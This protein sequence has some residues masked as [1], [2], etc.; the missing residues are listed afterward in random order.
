MLGEKFINDL[1]GSMTLQEK[2]AEMTQIW[3]E[4]PDGTLMGILRGF[5]KNAHLSENAGSLLGFNGAERVLEAQRIHMEENAHHIPLLFMTDVI[6]GYKTVFPSVLGL[7]ASWDPDLIEQSASV[8][9]AEASVSGVHVTFSP[10]ADLVRDARWGRV[11][12][13]TGEDSFLNALCAAAFTRGY[14]GSGIDRPLRIAACVKHFIGYGAVEG[15]RDYDSVQMSDYELYNEYLPAF[16]AA[17]DAGCEL[18]MPAFNT[19][20]GIPCSASR[21]LL[22][23]LLREELNFRGTVISD[24]TAVCELA[25]H[26][27]CE[28]NGQ[29]ASLALQ[30]GM[31][32]EM[33]SSTFYEHLT[34]LVESGAVGMHQ[35]DASVKR[36]LTLKDKM[37][38]FENPYKDADPEKEKELH[39]CAGH[40]RLAR[41]AAAKSLVLLKND[42]HVLPLGQ[43]EKLAL[44]GPFADSRQLLDIWGQVNGEEKDCVTLREALS[45]YSVEYAQGCR[46]WNFRNLEE[47]HLP[48]RELIDAAQALAAKS[49]KVIL[50]LGEHPDMS[51]E[52]GSRTDITLPENQTELLKAVQATGK[53]V[54]TIILAGRPLVLNTVSE[55]SS[56]L[57]FAWFPGTE[58][59]NGIADVL[60]GRYAP[61]ARLPMSFPR[62]V[63]QAPLYYNHLPT[64][65]PNTTGHYSAFSNGYIGIEPGPLYPFGYGLTYT[66]FA[67]S[68]VSLSASE[69]FCDSPSAKKEGSFDGNSAN[70]PET[71]EA[72]AEFVKRVAGC[73]LC[74]GRELLEAHVTVTNTG[75]TAGT[76]TVQLYVRDMAGAYSRPVRQLKAFRQIMLSPGEQCT[77]TFAIT[78][79]M[80]EYYIPGRGMSLEP[81]TFRIFIGP[82][83]EST[84]YQDFL[85]KGGY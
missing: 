57:L 41:E 23:D 26:G 27:V 76:E 75:Q 7:G 59:G 6:H 28:D 53:P 58:G 24:C 20:N 85:L 19:I 71:Y 46:L 50:V 8:A 29:A 18:L 68:P 17:I 5:H 21:P 55:Y 47:E 16:R 70:V 66:D 49:D 14:Q 79:E 40:R 51:A 1:I 64:G 15:G 33:V 67:Y 31:D 42:N 60:S 56:A 63:G 54:I 82:H 10:M 36:I 84:D 4:N 2:A 35:V 25:A 34:E 39:L 80:L 22:H 11:V 73:K 61:T 38:L 72:A 45:E 48:D 37:G 13:S 32:I 3:G 83:A 44:I 78:P 62:A 81:G 43:T 52:A 74:S 69:V 30:A 12:E 77:V 9:A 65:R